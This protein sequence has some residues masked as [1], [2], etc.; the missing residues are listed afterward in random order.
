MCI[1]RALIS[2]II[3][4]L[5][6]VHTPTSPILLRS[7]HDEALGCAL[8][9]KFQRENSRARVFP[10][11]PRYQRPEIVKQR[12]KFEYRRKRPNP[13][14]QDFIAYID[15]D[16]QLEALQLLRKKPVARELKKQNKKMK[17]SVSDFAGVSRI[18]EIYRLA[19]NRF[20]GDIELW[21]QYPDQYR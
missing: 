20:K 5:C 12:R 1:L 2:R 14:K 6:P 8:R 18:L 21:F 19:T 3:G 17:K 13:L 11:F 4:K 7:L 10:V 15:Y 9:I 16:K